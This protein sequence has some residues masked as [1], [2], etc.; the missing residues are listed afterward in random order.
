MFKRLM[1]LCWLA[2][3]PI[4]SVDAQVLYGSVIGNITDSSNAVIAGAAV[5]LISRET[6]QARETTTNDTGGYTFATLASGSYDLKVIKEG[7][8]SLT[9]PGVIV[10]INNITR[11]D[12]NLKVGSVTE[13]V[14]V[15]AQSA[16]LQTDRSEVR[17][18]VHRKSLENLP[19]HRAG[20]IS[21]YSG[22]ARLHAPRQRPFR[23]LQ[24]SRA[25]TFNVNGS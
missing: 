1:V 8:A 17:A 25:L 22:L 7:F 15:T 13:S 20:T 19:F 24:P 14:L 23:S 9:Q 6:G 12:L 18:E 5:T 11:V 21:S 10:S 4:A 3:G 16:I 2:L